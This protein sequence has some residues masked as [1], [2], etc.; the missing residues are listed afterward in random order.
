MAYNELWKNLFAETRGRRKGQLYRSDREWIATDTPGQK[1]GTVTATLKR[2]EKKHKQIMGD[3]HDRGW[4][5]GRN[6][7]VKGYIPIEFALAQPE[8]WYDDDAVDAF[9]KEFP[10]FSTNHNV[11][12]R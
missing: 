4:S 6:T 5:K 2:K 1:P 7:R 8:L 12:M 11:V 9:F 10:G 3:F